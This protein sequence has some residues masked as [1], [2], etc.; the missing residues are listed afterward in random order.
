MLRIALVFVGLLTCFGSAPAQQLAF[1]NRDLKDIQAWAREDTND[2]HRQYYLGLAHWKRHEWKQTDSL[3]RLAI[4]MEP[5]YSEA[6][7]A[8]ASLPYAR[9]TQLREEEM[10]DHVPEAWRL[11]VTEAREL[12]QRAFRTD[13]MVS[14]EILGIE[15]PEEPQALDYS[16]QAY[17]VYLRYYAWAVDLALG[18]YPSARERLTKLRSASLIRSQASLTKFLISFIGT[19][20][21]GSAQL[22]YDSPSPI[23]GLDRRLKLQQRDEVI[24]IPLDDNEYRFHARGAPSRRR[25]H[26]QRHRAVPGIAGARSGSRDGAHLPGKHLRAGRPRGRGVARAPACR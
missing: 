4:A 23:S 14:L 6:Y 19:Y 10:R 5:R 3:L 13:P 11:A 7:L 20:S 8:L 9:R 16:L 1:L 24:H 2:A 18:R 12:Y 25:T 21:R 17:Q 15:A 22:Q 26:G